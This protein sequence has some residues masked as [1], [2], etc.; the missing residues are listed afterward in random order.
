MQVPCYISPWS[1]TSRT[2]KEARDVSR[3]TDRD[4]DNCFGTTTIFIVE[5]IIKK[6]ALVVFMF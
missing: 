5:N 6:L 1:E 4:I 2:P 3:K